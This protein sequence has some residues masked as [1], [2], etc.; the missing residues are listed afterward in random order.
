MVDEKQQVIET[1]RRYLEPYQPADYR[2]NV[3]ETGIRH[4]GDDWWEVV[5]QPDR[6]DIRSYDYYGRLAEAENDI[7]DH[8]HLKILLVPVLPG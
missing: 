6:D 8:E 2:L 7:E 3:I 5:V 1:V 4:T